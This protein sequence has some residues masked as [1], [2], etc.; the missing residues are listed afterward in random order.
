MQTDMSRDSRGLQAADKPR[1]GVSLVRWISSPG[2]DG[3]SG[4]GGLSTVPGDAS[5]SA[6]APARRPDLTRRLS[7]TG[8]PRP[9]WPQSASPR[10]RDTANY[11][12]QLVTGG[13]GP[14]WGVR[15]AARREPWRAGRAGRPWSRTGAPQT[16]PAADKQRVR[17]A[18]PHALAR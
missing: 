15:A 13:A 5:G 10:E 17:E 4:D 8:W 6:P 16:S 14:F 3:S 7:V 11:L 9:P 2:A 12:S 1:V 18:T